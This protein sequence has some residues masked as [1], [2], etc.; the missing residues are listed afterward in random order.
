MFE[1]LKLN[2]SF[3]DIKLYH[4]AIELSFQR[5]DFIF[6]N[7]DFEDTTINVEIKDIMSYF[8]SNTG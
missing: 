6:Q 1:K 8:V 5:I 4:Q 7:R 2:W 3:K